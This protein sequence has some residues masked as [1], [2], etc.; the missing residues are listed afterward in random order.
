MLYKNILNYKCMDCNFS[1]NTQITN[2]RKF[3]KIFVLKK[4]LN[5]LERL[6]MMNHKKVLHFCTIIMLRKNDTAIN[7]L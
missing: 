6:F 4:G 1:R 5:C 7:L 2:F 3:H